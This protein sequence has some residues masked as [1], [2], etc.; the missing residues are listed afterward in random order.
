MGPNTCINWA[1]IESFDFLSKSIGP[2][3][4]KSIEQSVR[5]SGVGELMSSGL[6]RQCVLSYAW[7]HSS[8]LV[9]NSNQNSESKKIKSVWKRLL[10]RDKN[11]N[12]LSH[13]SGSIY[14]RQ[15]KKINKELKST[16]VTIMALMDQPLE[17]GLCNVCPKHRSFGPKKS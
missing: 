10:P 3:F 5:S 14:G 13:S 6:P 1:Q 15:I 11:K 12:E 16:Y 7:P 17:L 9:E 2:C 4:N 8:R